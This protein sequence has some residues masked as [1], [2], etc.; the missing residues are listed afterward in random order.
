M[1]QIHTRLQYLV[2]LGL[3]AQDRI[4]RSP[5]HQGPHIM[6]SHVNSALLAL[7]RLAHT[8]ILKVARYLQHSTAACLRTRQW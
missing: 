8:N 2:D 6:F 1:L 4:A 7:A 5:I 3:L